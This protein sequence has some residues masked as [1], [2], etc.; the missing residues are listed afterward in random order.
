MT[1]ANTDDDLRQGLH[2]IALLVT[3][4]TGIIRY[5]SP[6]ALEPWSPGA[7]E[8][9]SPGARARFG[10]ENPIGTSLERMVPEDL[11]DRTGPDFGG[12]CDARVPGIRRSYQHSRA[13][14]RRS[15][16]IAATPR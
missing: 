4:T 12:P 13:L 10:H 11:R 14:R 9:W 15:S 2:S 8:P 16:Q 7:L 6:G 3:D 1:L 5:W